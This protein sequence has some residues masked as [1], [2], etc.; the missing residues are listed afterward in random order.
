M[1]REKA[2]S[3]AAGI[4]T[5]PAPGPA[6]DL[7]SRATGSRRIL[8][9]SPKDVR[10]QFRPVSATISPRAEPFSRLSP[11]TAW[12][13]SSSKRTR[14]AVRAT[15][16][17]AVKEKKALVAFRFLRLLRATRLGHKET[18]QAQNWWFAR[19]PRRR[20]IKLLSQC[21]LDKGIATK[22]S[23]AHS[24]KDSL[25]P[26]FKELNVHDQS[27]AAV[28]HVESLSR[29]RVINEQA[30]PLHFETFNPYQH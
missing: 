14:S 25:E 29:K 4:K 15:T 26:L 22:T 24:N 30:T 8:E 9:R 21:K 18:Q 17:R 1:D 10:N 2:Q 16:A 27:A 20:A 5:G 12:R 23:V 6:D 13:A 3:T 11:S 19:R 7:Q 28:W